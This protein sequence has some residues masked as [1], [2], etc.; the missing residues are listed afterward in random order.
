MSSGGC[1]N[2]RMRRGD[3][4]R[5]GN[6]IIIEVKSEGESAARVLVTAPQEVKILIERGIPSPFHLKVASDI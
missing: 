4:I 3:V 5:V 1:L 6:D 2:I